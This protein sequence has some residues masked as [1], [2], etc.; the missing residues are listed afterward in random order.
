MLDVVRCRIRGAQNG[1][2]LNQA[3]TRTD[4]KHESRYRLRD[5]FCSHRA[6]ESRDRERYS[7]EQ[8]VQRALQEHHSP[9]GFALGADFDV[10]GNPRHFDN[11]VKK[12]VATR[13]VEPHLLEAV[14]EVHQTIEQPVFQIRRFMR[15]HAELA[16]LCVEQHCCDAEDYDA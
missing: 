14:Q 11:I 1:Y 8:S 5:G 16:A 2:R 15:R 13:A 3:K 4:D 9:E 12:S 6:A 7:A 10:G